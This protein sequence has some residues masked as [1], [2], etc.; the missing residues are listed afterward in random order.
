[1]NKN[2]V[3]VLLKTRDSI[4]TLK[5]KFENLIIKENTE[6]ELTHIYRQGVS[7][8]NRLI[9]ELDKKCLDWCNTYFV[10]RWLL[11]INGM[12]PYLAAGLLAYFDV[13]GKECAAQFIKYSG[14]SDICVP[15][16]KNVQEI[17]FKLKDRFLQSPDS[18]YNQLREKKYNELLKDFTVDISK[19]DLRADRYM[20]KTFLAHLFEE[21][22]RE[23]HNGMPPERHTYDNLKIIEPEVPYTR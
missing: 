21:M 23:E 5:A 20:L 22:Y 11:Q 15:H 12:T 14:V 9:C 19:I 7:D 2:D 18:L 3:R 4:L 1:M 10:G 8:M 13:S 17:V 16:S 6:I